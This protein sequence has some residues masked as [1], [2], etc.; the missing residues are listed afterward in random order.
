MCSPLKMNV[1]FLKLGLQKFCKA[2]MP[3][4]D[5]PEGF[6]DLP[7][8]RHHQQGFA[9]RG[10]VAGAGFLLEVLRHYLQ[11]PVPLCGLC[12]VARGPRLLV[13][14][15]EVLGSLDIPSVIVSCCRVAECQPR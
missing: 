12:L 6:A 3:G 2:K 9:P 8:G 15:A 11:A 5:V 14:F 4:V 13:C 10:P 1:L 7:V